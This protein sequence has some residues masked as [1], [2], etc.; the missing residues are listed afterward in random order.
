MLGRA[1][2]VQSA[3][4]RTPGL[5]GFRLRHFRF[6]TLLSALAILA[7]TPRARRVD[8]PIVLVGDAADTVRLAQPAT[9]IVSLLPTATEVLFG[10]GAGNALVGRSAWCDYP[11][12]AL[13][14]TSLGDALFAPNLEVIAS[15]EP[16]LVLL[17]AGGSNTTTAERLR[18]M[19]M[20]TL[21]IRTD[22]LE[23]VSK[24][25]ALLG[26][27][28]G[29]ERA[30]DSLVAAF[31]SDLDAATT[32]DSAGPTVFILAWGQPLT[33]LGRGSFVSDLIVRAGGRNLFGDIAAPSAPVGI[34]TVAQRH[35][36][37]TLFITASD[38]SPRVRPEWRAVPALADTSRFLHFAGSEFMRPTP[39]APGAIRELHAALGRR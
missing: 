31:R 30:A 32:R 8:A 17:Y 34:E 29:H 7:C 1:A 2:C 10:I 39:R 22:L 14:V 11:A 28:T 38:A 15:L 26:R 21:L 4:Y 6:A 16:D 20:P 37:W 27:A 35:P 13:R 33:T 25:A 24:V 5:G 18:T 19:G 12:E 36:D 3:Q 9:R 23:D